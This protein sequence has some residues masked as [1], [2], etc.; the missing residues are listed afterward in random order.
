MFHY[1]G[2]VS[3]CGALT[4]T[5]I[6]KTLRLVALSNWDFQSQVIVSNQ[7]QNSEEKNPSIVSQK[8]SL[9]VDL[10]SGLKWT[11]AH[12]PQVAS[13]FRGFEVGMPEQKNV[14]I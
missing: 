8:N 7:Y 3:L 10:T 13:F 5:N 1:F 11:R 6:R 14:T 12:S 2:S 9:H 4:L